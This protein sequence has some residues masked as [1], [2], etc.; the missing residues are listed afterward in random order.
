MQN[1]GRLCGRICGGNFT[2]MTSIH[3]KANGTE[4]NEGVVCRD[5]FREDR[6]IREIQ[7][8]EVLVNLCQEI[9]ERRVLAI[10]SVS[11]PYSTPIL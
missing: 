9:Q 2:A 7:N 5:N 3:C 1:S 10:Y 11:M 4:Y 6:K 8:D